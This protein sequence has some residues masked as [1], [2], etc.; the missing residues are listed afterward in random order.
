MAAIGQTQGRKLEENV[1]AAE[2]GDGIGHWQER[3][4]REIERGPGY[5]PSKGFPI[6]PHF[7]GQ[8]ISSIPTFKEQ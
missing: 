1:L 6:D 8:I 5:W 2:A 3:G 7:A 4:H